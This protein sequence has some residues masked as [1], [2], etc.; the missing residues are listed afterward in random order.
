MLSAGGNRPETPGSGMPRAQPRGE[1][2]V[3]LAQGVR[4]PRR[5]GG[6]RREAALTDRGAEEEGYAEPERFCGKLAL[7]FCTPP[8]NALTLTMVAVK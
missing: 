8:T 5:R 7:G 6:L 2:V 1:R 3:A 4:R